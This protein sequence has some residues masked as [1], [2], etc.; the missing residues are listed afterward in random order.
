MSMTFA[1]TVEARTRP[2]KGMNMTGK[3]VYAR[4]N[5]KMLKIKSWG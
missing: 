3:F 4:G 2:M 5:R 1:E